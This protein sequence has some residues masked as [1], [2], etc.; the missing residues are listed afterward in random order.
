[1]YSARVHKQHVKYLSVEF[2]RTCPDEQ[3]RSRRQFIYK[4]RN[5]TSQ[6]FI[7]VVSFVDALDRDI[8]RGTWA[9]L[10]P[11][12]IGGCD[13]ISSETR[14]NWNNPSIGDIYRLATETRTVT[15]KS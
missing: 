8:S 13:K 1:M 14:C 15:V 4:N 12:N 7:N 11:N 9:K 10:W 6:W 3:P 2:M 5:I